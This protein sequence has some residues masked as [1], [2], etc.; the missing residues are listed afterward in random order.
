MSGRDARGSLGYL[1]VPSFT[2]R[3]ATLNDSR[4]STITSP[5][6]TNYSIFVQ[7]PF[8]VTPL[9]FKVLFNLCMLC[10]FSPSINASR[11]NP[12]FAGSLF[13][14]IARTLSYT[15][16]NIFLQRFL[17]EVNWAYATNSLIWKMWQFWLECTFSL[18][19]SYMCFGIDAYLIMH[20][21][22]TKHL[23]D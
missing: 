19:F 13:I 14:Y 16:A 7:M 15:K 6:T 20:F 22:N 23:N 8:W 18:L 3:P 5:V 21:F 10:F 12:T 4:R 11:Y 17:Y 9:L 1:R 2:T